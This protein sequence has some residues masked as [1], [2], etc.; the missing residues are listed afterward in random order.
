MAAPAP[1]S[2][3]FCGSEDTHGY[4]DGSGVCGNCGRA[5]RGSAA[6]GTAAV[7]ETLEPVRRGKV[8]REPIRMGI[9]GVVGGV[10][11]YVAIPVSFLIVA[12]L[13]RVPVDVVIAGILNTPFGAFACLGI[14]LLVVFGWLAMWAGFLVW[15]GFH[16]RSTYLL[17][18]GIALIVTSLAL[19]GGILGIA[20]GALAVIA[21]TLTRWKASAAPPEGGAA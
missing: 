13:S 5:F 18:A 12:W 4:E 8:A 19:A 21:G 10:L 3:P 7:G 17:V 20:G 2:C 14:V 11:A 9:A 1:R 6:A 15:Q 16:E